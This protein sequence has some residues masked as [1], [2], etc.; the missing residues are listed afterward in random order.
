MQGEMSD[1]NI[2]TCQNASLCVLQKAS[3][4]L[5][6]EDST[7][8]AKH[9]TTME[10]V[11]GRPK[12]TQ[13]AEKGRKKRAARHPYRSLQEVTCET[14]RGVRLKPRADGA[15]VRDTNSD[16]HGESKVMNEVLGD[17]KRKVFEAGKLRSIEKCRT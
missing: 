3:S 16:I 15:V 17:G 9:L 1:G 13:T 10:M 7:A 12:K 5:D 4:D 2:R 14:K 8:L 11:S 6:A